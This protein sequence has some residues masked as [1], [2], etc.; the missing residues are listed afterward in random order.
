LRVLASL[1]KKRFLS[2]CLI[3]IAAA[4]VFWYPSADKRTR[5]FFAE[6]A[7]QERKAEMAVAWLKSIPDRQSDGQTEFLMAR[8]YRRLGDLDLVR[9]H[10]QLAYDQGFSVERLQREQ[11]LAM[12][13]SGQMRDAE[14]HLRRLLQDPGDDG[15]EICES[16]VSGYFR[17]RQILKAMPIIDAWQA[18][19]PDDPLPYSIRAGR[20]REL[21][22]WSEAIAAYRKALEL[23]PADSDIRLQLAICLK[24]SLKFD[25]AEIEF[26]K[27][28]KET[29]Q[30]KA[31]LAEWGDMLLSVGKVSDATGVFEQLLAIDPEN[32]DARAAMGGILLMNG[33]ASDAVSMLRPLYAERPY[34]SKVRYSLASSLQAAGKT[35]EAAEMFQQVN[36]AEEQLR[37]K[38]KLL[39]ELANSP[40]PVK[41]RYEIAI[42]AMNHESPEEGLRWLTTVIDMDPGHSGAYAAL[43]DYY[44]RVGNVQLEKNYRTLAESS[45]RATGRP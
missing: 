36:A 32:Y 44:R 16:Y 6:R 10:I 21:E 28:L 38:R 40:D 25:E 18:D 42:I 14:P 19:Y 9:E 20:F 7:L 33:K 41:Q 35:E 5:I 3:L 1:S 27:C 26:R 17:N 12:A 24:A 2:V 4:T 45:E 30:E 13:Q 23:T 15:R 31:L 39:D 11:W 34:D 8:A 22:H 43:A 29:P 37:R